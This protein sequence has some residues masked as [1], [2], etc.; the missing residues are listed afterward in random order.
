MEN[1]NY[2]SDYIKSIDDQIQSL[3]RGVVFL[4]TELSGKNETINILVDSVSRTESGNITT[5]I[6]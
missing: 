2:L 3:K 1:N 4:R 5:N 6:H